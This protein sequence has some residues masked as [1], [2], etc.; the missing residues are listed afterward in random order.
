[1]ADLLWDDVKSFFDPDLMGSLADVLV[2]EA[3]MEDWQTVLEV[4]GASGWMCQYSE[5]E[6]GASGG[7][8]AFDQ[9]CPRCV[10]QPGVARHPVGLV[11]FVEGRAGTTRRPNSGS[12]TAAS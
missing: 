10:I 9:P 2:P 3:S 4:V 8:S 7:G 11:D 5:G 1:M 12:V 6:T